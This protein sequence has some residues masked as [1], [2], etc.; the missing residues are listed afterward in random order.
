MSE[1]S[2]RCMV[3]GKVTED[4]STICPAC[5][6]SIRGEATGQRK[7]LVKAAE[8]EIKRHGLSSPETIPARGEK[9]R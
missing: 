6:E 1:T 8:K 7:K 3:C 9:K 2:K 4:G 5:N